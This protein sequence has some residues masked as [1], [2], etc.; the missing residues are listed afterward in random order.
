M[1]LSKGIIVEHGGILSHASIVARELGIPA[2]IGITG[3][4]EQ[5]NSGDI[6]F[7]DGEKG[8]VSKVKE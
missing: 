1:A 5:F 7:I 3:A 2:V 4:C 6:L 8:F